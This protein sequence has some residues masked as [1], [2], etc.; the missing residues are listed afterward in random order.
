MKVGH[1]ILGIGSGFVTYESIISLK[2]EFEYPVG[3]RNGSRREWWAIQNS[4]SCA[5]PSQQ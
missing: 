1:Q 3:C 5:E 2:R 4:C